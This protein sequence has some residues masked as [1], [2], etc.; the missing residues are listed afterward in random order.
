MYKIDGISFQKIKV[1]LTAAKYENLTKAADELHMTQASV[2]RN[3]VSME[4]ELGV[5][6]FI[7]H[8]RRVRLTNAG[9]ALVKD[10]SAIVRQT[11]KAID[12]AHK[13]QQNQFNWLSI[14]DYS[15]T[16][17]DAYLL[18]VTQKFEEENPGVELVIERLDPIGLLEKLKEGKYDAVFFASTG[19]SILDE[20]GLNHI[21]VLSLNPC[22]IISNTHP[23]FGKEYLGVED[24]K[25]QTMVAMHG[26]YER[27]WLF[28]K[29][30]CAD[31]KLDYGEVRFVD[32][33][34]TL[35]M[36]LRRGDYMTIMDRCFAPIDI[37]QLR[38]IEL[39]DCKK[40][41][42]FVL[43][44]SPDNTNPYLKKLTMICEEFSRYSIK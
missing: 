7:R 3:I 41:C 19:M 11:E 1:F 44:Y 25:G 2:S 27:Y 24:F 35:A 4:L 18:P 33:P 23:L 17:I 38:Y 26:A 10:L 12:N 21:P 42:G 16:P 29:E 6:L 30:V 14:G 22:I 31:I 34:H 40:K 5:A 8:K 13:L 37:G 20:E 15:T 43:V 28:I 9:A 36:E 39:P 32:N